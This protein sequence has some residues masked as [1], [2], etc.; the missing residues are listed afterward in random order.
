MVLSPPQ[1]KSNFNQYL[2]LTKPRLALGN[3]LVAGAAFIF[4]SP[5][6]I[7]W[8]AFAFMFLGLWCVI[9]SAC[10]FNNIY[11]RGIDAKMERT[12]SRALVTG[13]I[14]K[15]SAM[16]FGTALLMIGI[17]LLSATNIF[18]LGAAAVGWATYVLWYTPL[19][20]RSSL[21]LYVGAVSGATP[22]VVGYAAAAG[23]LDW[24]AAGLFVILYLWQLP[25]FLAIARY[26]FDEYAAANV[27]LAVMRPTSDTQKLRAR[28]IFYASLVVLVAVSILLI[29]QRW[30]R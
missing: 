30:V 4:G 25:H 24:Y 2:E 5:E 14:A 18:A 29:L 20:H 22:P 13:I 1:P 12:R 26:R 8:N 3:L 17:G 6:V 23:M 27:P 21:A 10:V 19:K 9:G 16:L 11:D 15:T 7:D 28:K